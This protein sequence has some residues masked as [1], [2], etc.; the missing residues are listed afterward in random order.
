MSAFDKVCPQCSAANSA[1][2]VLCECGYLFNPIYLKD[3]ELALELAIRE[4]SLIEEYLAARA[5]QAIAAARTAAHHGAKEPGNEQKAAQAAITQHAAAVAQAELA[6][7]CVRTAEAEG[8]LEAHRDRC[9][10][11]GKAQPGYAD[12]WR[13]IIVAEALK[14]KSVRSPLVARDDDSRV[15]TSNGAGATFTSM[16]AAKADEVMKTAPRLGT[17]QCPACDATLAAN[18][19]RCQCGWSVSMPLSE[20]AR[21]QARGGGKHESRRPSTHPGK[22]TKPR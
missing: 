2:A 15:T 4:E 20:V 17:T 1:G 10:R 19:G 18:G 3:P 6:R 14:A 16:Q 21:L 7:Q 11:S 13:A 12:G 22:P 9:R 5:E 8:R